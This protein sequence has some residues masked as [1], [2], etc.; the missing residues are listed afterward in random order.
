MS[1]NKTASRSNASGYFVAELG[2]DRLLTSLCENYDQPLPS[3]T[4]RFR[5][6][7]EIKPLLS[8]DQRERSMRTVF[9]QTLTR[10]AL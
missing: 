6:F 7:S 4:A 10:A 5:R 1:W 2:K 9:T 8:R 3:V